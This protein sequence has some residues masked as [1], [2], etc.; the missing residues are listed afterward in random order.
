VPC[1]RALSYPVDPHRTAAVR[2]NYQTDRQTDRP[3]E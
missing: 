3:A 2:I 1:Q